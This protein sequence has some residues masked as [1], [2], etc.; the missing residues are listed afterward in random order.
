MIFEI[1][2]REILIGNPEG[3]RPLGNKNLIL[4]KYSPQ[5]EMIAARR[6]GG[7]CLAPHGRLLTLDWGGGGGDS[8]LLL[9]RTEENAVDLHSVAR[10]F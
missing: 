9:H 2:L 1:D 8:I 7:I 6:G 5:T 10:G 4:C 3:K